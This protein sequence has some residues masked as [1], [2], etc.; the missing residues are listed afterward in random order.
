[1]NTMAG[2]GKKSEA[3]HR[4]GKTEPTPKAHKTLDDKLEQGL[5]ESFRG[6]IPFRLP[7]RRTAATIPANLDPRGGATGGRTT[8]VSTYTIDPTV[9]SHTFRVE[10][11]LPQRVTL[12]NIF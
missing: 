11:P 3:K 12:L 6:R 10:E 5:E 4:G 1:M 2:Q 7:S 9:E 8:G